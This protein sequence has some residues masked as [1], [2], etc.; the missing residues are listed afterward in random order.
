MRKYVEE[1]KKTKK[2]KMMGPTLISIVWLVFSKYS[3]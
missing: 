1:I 2:K 3:F